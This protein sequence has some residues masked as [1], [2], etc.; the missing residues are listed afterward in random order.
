MSISS[1]NPRP[2]TFDVAA[3][4]AALD[5]TRRARDLTWT[6]AA[7]EIGV[8]PSTL[9]GLRGRT[10]VEG[11]GVLQMLRWLE[12][13]P[14]AFTVGSHAS[15]GGTL[16]SVGPGEV[17]RFDAAAIYRALDAQR[18][19]RQWTWPKLAAAIGGVSPSM[20]THLANGGR[21]SMPSIVRII[22]WLGRPVADFTRASQ[23]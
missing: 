22:G 8:S 12:R 13:A 18:D 3:L 11:D 15:R 6:A 9:T 1:R 23:R 20:L 2:G 19:A 4:Y 5:E 14:E 7:R 10:S 21:V 16:P 17:L